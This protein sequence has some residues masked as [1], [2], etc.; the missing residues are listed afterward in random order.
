MSDAADAQKLDAATE[1]EK[2]LVAAAVLA[3]RKRAQVEQQEN[4]PPWAREITAALLALPDDVGEKGEPHFTQSFD[5]DMEP[6]VHGTASCMP[7]GLPRSME[8]EFKYNDVVDG[9][10]KW[11]DDYEYVVKEPAVE[12]QVKVW[13]LAPTHT[14]DLG[15]EGWRLSNFTDQH[16]CPA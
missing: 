6:V 3:E 7:D 8:D 12:K 14:R 2:Q 10:G 16:V 1:R 15:H 13:S 4:P 9:R 11:M 5:V